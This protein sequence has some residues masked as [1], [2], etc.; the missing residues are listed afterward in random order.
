MENQIHCAGPRGEG[1]PASHCRLPRGWGHDLHWFGRRPP[2]DLK[3]TLIPVTRPVPKQTAGC[4]PGGAGA[5]NRGGVLLPLHT[6][7]CA[8]VWDL[9]RGSSVGSRGK[10][11][12]FTATVGREV[13]LSSLTAPSKGPNQAAGCSGSGR[14]QC[15]AC[16]DVWNA[17][18]WPGPPCRDRLAHTTVCQAHTGAVRVECLMT[19]RGSKGAGDTILDTRALDTRV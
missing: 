16:G 18:P 2:G 14:T 11:T 10:E 13:T 19:I 17:G 3:W 15:Q 7:S 5:W 6:V 4:G 1:Q 12:A 8:R 9:E